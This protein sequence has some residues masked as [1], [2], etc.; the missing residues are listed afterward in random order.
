MPENRNMGHRLGQI[1]NPKDL[2]VGGMAGHLLWWRSLESM[3][4]GLASKG[5]WGM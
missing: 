4:L 3:A 1:S 5:V 2:E